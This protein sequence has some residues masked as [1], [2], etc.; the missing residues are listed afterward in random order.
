MPVSLVCTTAMIAQY[1][2]KATMQMV[3]EDYAELCAAKGKPAPTHSVTA[4]AGRA[5]VNVGV[6]DTNV[7][8]PAKGGAA[9]PLVLQVGTI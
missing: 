2:L 8:E 3:E 5:G 1:G 4:G 9:P 7:A 6:L